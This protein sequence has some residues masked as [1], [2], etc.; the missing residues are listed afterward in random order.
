MKC[1]HC[2]KPDCIREVLFRNAENYGGGIFN[3]PCTKCRKMITV[4]ASRKVIIEGISKSEK[5]L[6]EADWGY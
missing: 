4:Y 6:E 5:K 1:P 3:L 2:N